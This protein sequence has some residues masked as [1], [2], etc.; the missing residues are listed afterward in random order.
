MIQRSFNDFNKDLTKSNIT[1]RFQLC[2]TVTKLDKMIRVKTVNFASFK[3][4]QIYMLNKIL[5]FSILTFNTLNLFGQTFEEGIRQFENENYSSALSTFSKLNATNPKNSIYAYYM[6][7]VLYAMEN[8]QGAKVAYNAGLTANS[9]CDECKIGLGKLELDKNNN[10]E[11]KKLFD[12]ALRGNSK[13]HQIIAMVGDAYLYSKSPNPKLA[14]EYLTNARD[15]DPKIA[16]Y[17]IHK[18]DAHLAADDLGAAMTAY[19]TAVEKNKNE[20]ETYI[21]MARI[22]NSSAKY[23]LAIEKLEKAIQIDSNYA[24]AYK[25][26]YESYIKSGNFKK[27]IPILERYVALAGSDVGAK[28]RLV[29]FLCF[30]AKDYDRAIEEGNKIIA[31]HPEE[32]TIY[33]WLAWSYAETNK[34]NESFEANKKL[35]TEVAKDTNR[36]VYGSDYEYFGKV[37]AKLKKIDTAEWAYLKVIELESSREAEIYGLLAKANYDSKNYSSAEKWYLKKN[38]IKELSNTE[39]HYLGLSQFYA[40]AY[41]RADSSFAKV[42]AVTPNYANG[43]LMRAKCNVQLDPDNVNFLA[44]PYF[45][46]YIELAEVDKTKESIKKNLILSY[47]YL[48]YYYVQNND[49]ETAKTFFTKSIELDPKD[50]TAVNAVKVLNKK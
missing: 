28:V 5:I 39:M 21:K 17:W 22:W 24:L 29:K 11:A 31:D 40:E 32:Y 14:L 50:E 3:I 30:Q 10:A 19:E 20:P 36:K 15:L 26:L 16:K 27:V 23:D 44:K 46:K 1:I 43:W 37:A 8:Y 41:S 4:K 42:V 35:F 18:G 48:G 9:K 45:E 13:N 47:N 6:G 7:E 38:S 49:N 25:E 34:N 12:S 2:L 33:R